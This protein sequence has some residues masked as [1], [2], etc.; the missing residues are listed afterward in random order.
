[1]CKKTQKTVLETR[2]WTKETHHFNRKVTHQD[3]TY[4]PYSCCRVWSATCGPPSAA[5]AG[6]QQGSR[7]LAPTARWFAPLHNSN[8]LLRPGSAV[9]CPPR[10]HT[11]SGAVTSTSPAASTTNTRSWASL[12]YQHQQR[13]SHG[14]HTLSG[15][16]SNPLT[17]PLHL[18]RRAQKAYR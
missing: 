17:N 14:W 2:T 11:S 15:Y 9:T 8:P 7:L 1:M 12:L 13:W 16:C 4:S 3:N 5:P 10:H 6:M 18:R